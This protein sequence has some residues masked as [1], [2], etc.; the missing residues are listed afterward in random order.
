MEMVVIESFL[1]VRFYDGNGITARILLNFELMKH[2]YTPI[3][4]TAEDR[5]NTTKCWILHIYTRMNYEPF[6]KLISELV[7][8]SEKFWLSVLE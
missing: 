8:E 2:G 3:I 4:I 7:I 1:F 6:I 5:A